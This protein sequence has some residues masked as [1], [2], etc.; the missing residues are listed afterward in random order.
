MKKFIVYLIV[1]TGKK[2]PR[3][4]IG[5]TNIERFNSGYM[6]S[7]RSKKYEKIYYNELNENP[8]LFNKFILSFHESRKEA[9][10]QEYNIQK[11]Y[12]VVVNKN[13][14]NMSTASKNG[15]FGMDV[16]GENNP[17]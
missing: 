4:Y 2:L 5:S 14:I 10:L 12:N 16:R 11:R 7:V 15:F 17:N 9:L 3:Y 1:Y 6:G 13:F 8:L